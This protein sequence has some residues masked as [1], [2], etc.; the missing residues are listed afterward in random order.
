MKKLTTE[1]KNK[2]VSYVIDKIVN[3][4]LYS[5]EEAENMVQNSIFVELLNDDPKVTLHYSVEYWV[6]VI[7]DENK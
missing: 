3:K 7:I 1:E 4:H 2:F 6:E 5:R